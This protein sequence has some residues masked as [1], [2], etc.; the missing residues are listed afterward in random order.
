[1]HKYY[2][3]PFLFFYKKKKD[4]K[5]LAVHLNYSNVADR[6]RERKGNFKL[7]GMKNHHDEN[8]IFNFSWFLSLFFSLLYH[9]HISY[10]ITWPKAPML[11]PKEAVAA[12]ATTSITLWTPSSES[13]DWIWFIVCVWDLWWRNRKLIEWVSESWILRKFR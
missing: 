1:M 2:F 5:K 11:L 6:E 9:M 12:A 3:C 4:Y 8:A 7:I 13:Y 10:T